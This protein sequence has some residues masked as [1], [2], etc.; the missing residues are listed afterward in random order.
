MLSIVDLNVGFGDRD[1]LA[2]AALQVEPGQGALVCGAGATGKST[3]LAAA[4]GII[5]RLNHADRYAGDIRLFGQS[6]LELPRADLFSRIGIVFQNL[7]DQLWDLEVEDVVAAPLE[8]R[9]LPRPQIR[10]RLH[11]LFIA[12]QLRPL[13]GRRVLTLSGGERRLVV[14]AAA[15][16]AHPQLLVLDEPTTGLDPAARARLDEALLAV[17]DQIPLV[18]AADQDAASLARSIRQV[19]LLSGGRIGAS[20]PAHE[21]LSLQAPWLDAGVLPPRRHRQ[22]VR[23][24]AATGAVLL[25]SDQ[26]RTRL[27]R[28]SGEPVLR[29]VSFSI[30]AGEIVGLIG[31]NGAGKST[32]I[33]AILGMAATASGTVA[34][35]G[36]NSSR[37]TTARRARRI[38]YLPQNMR[39]MLFNLTVLDEVAFSLAGTTSGMSDPSVRQRG[40]E[41]LRPYGLEDLAEA[42]PFALSAR[43]QALLGLA[44]VAAAGC[45]VAIL[46][47]P[48]LARDVRGRAMLDRFL[49]DMLGAGRSVVL[50]SH[51]LDL[52][53]E[54][55]GRLLILDEGRIAFDGPTDG[56]WT[57]EAFMSLGWP[58]PRERWRAAS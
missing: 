46:D 17:R 15:L 55:C 58:S 43:Q 16:A 32:L 51:D 9:G 35:E 29:D 19:H 6:V 14:L 7:D 3:L 1:V 57:S 56:G 44:C 4:C 22:S 12:L 30:R 47:E 52:V 26:L 2:G 23:P 27:A 5:P 42:T 21:A 10:D 50:I 11:E 18:L 53:D 45:A 13:S 41:A 37:W 39:R 24:S 31:R 34:I 54:L 25:E 36:E 40:L 48:L 33:Q 20:W 8:N 49:D 38:G 28:P